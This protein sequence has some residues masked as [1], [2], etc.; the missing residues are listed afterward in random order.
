MELSTLQELFVDELRDT[1][2]AE[3]QLLKELPRLAKKATSPDLQEAFSDHEKETE[4]QIKR[5]EKIFDILGSSARAKTCKGMKGILEEGH[6]MIEETEGDEL[7]DAL[8]IGSAQKAEH[9]EIASYGILRTYASVL[10]NKEVSRLLDQ[11]LEEEKACDRK[12]TELAESHIN[13]EAANA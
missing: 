1:L 3:K 12:L 5:L 11:T 7:I 6:E 4:G 2:H 10:G 13:E 9:Y 8:L